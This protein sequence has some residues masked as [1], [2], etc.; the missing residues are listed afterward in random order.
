MNSICIYGIYSST[1]V[2][3]MW[4]HHITVYNIILIKCKI[5]IRCNNYSAHNAN[6]S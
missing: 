1:S 5:Y 4:I 3:S 6:A 2:Y